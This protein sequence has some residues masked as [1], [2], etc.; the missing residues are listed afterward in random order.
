VY[1]FQCHLELDQQRMHWLIQ[2]CPGDL[3]PD[4]Y[5]QEPEVILSQDYNSINQHLDIF[6]QKFILGRE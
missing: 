1:G 3:S 4:R 2:H 5:V 6:L